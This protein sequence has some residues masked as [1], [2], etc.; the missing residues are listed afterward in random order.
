[1]IKSND[2]NTQPF[3][4]TLHVT[5]NRSSRLFLGDSPYFSLKDISWETPLNEDICRE[6]GRQ[7]PHVEGNSHSPPTLPGVPTL[8]C[9]LDLTSAL[10]EALRET[11]WD[12]AMAK[13]RSHMQSFMVTG[14][15][16]QTSGEI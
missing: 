1:M 9:H 12:S 4:L 10:Q 2:S 7:L 13:V 16:P 3:I 11:L 15:V 6:G 14:L 8:R 5:R